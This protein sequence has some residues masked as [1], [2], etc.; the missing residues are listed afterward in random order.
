MRLKAIMKESTSIESR[1]FKW[2][3]REERQVMSKPYLLLDHLPITTLNVPNKSNIILV[4]TRM[5]ASRRSLVVR[6]NDNWV[7]SAKQNLSVFQSAIHL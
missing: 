5:N 2:T 6:R 3:A 1:V 7:L 4:K